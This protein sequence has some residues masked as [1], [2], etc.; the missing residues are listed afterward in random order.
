MATSE[1]PTTDKR[2]A[3]RQKDRGAE[4]KERSLLLSLFQDNSR[5]E[6]FESSTLNIVCIL[7]VDNLREISMFTFDRRRRR[8][9]CRCTRMEGVN[10]GD[11]TS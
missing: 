4:G 9:C 3:D 10:C 11:M 8:R 1:C 5:V 7:M 2:Q 6:E